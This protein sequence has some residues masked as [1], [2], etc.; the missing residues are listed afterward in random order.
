MSRTDEYF[1]DILRAFV[2]ETT[3]P[4]SEE[5]DWARIYWLAKIH[6]V[7]GII[8][9]MLK[10][11]PPEQQP[12]NEYVSKFF[13]I[14]NSTILCCAGRGIVMDRLLESYGD[15]GVPAVPMKGYIVRDFYPVKELRTFGD[16]DFLIREEDREKSHELMLAKGYIC[17]HP[18][19]TVF[20][21]GG[22]VWTYESA[23]KQ[24]MYEIHTSLLSANI[25]G[26]SEY[27]EYVRHAWEH[28][29]CVNHV[30][31]DG[32][33]NQYRFNETFHFIYVLLHLAKH[34]ASFGAGIRMFMDIA[35]I[36]K[37][38]P[39][40]DWDAVMREMRELELDDFFGMV[41]TLCNRWF[42]TVSPVE[43][44]TKVDTVL[45]DELSG[46]ILSGGVFG[47]EN[48]DESTLKMKKSRD[49]LGAV[50]GRKIKLHV[51]LKEL[52]A[53]FPFMSSRYPV[54]KKVPFLLPIFWVMR[55][56]DI[57]IHQ[58]KRGAQLVKGVFDDKDI[59][60]SY[61]MLSAMGLNTKR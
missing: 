60:K 3:I 47:F 8:G 50:S 13:Q 18:S 24:E 55:W 15:A 43:I 26:N 7:S 1:T 6:S 45:C 27:V 59:Q 48:E 52:F 33:T 44:G 51:I 20:Q 31:F 21:Q 19:L 54:L 25:N 30:N 61:R 29:N 9:Y 41:M 39:P 38:A 42:G 16:I 35:L 46:Y 56:I 12:V 23:N 37:A 28:V 11:L 53:E 2:N 40:I 4:I 5:V 17:T 10:Q 22:D 34:C 57:F 36:V 32:E 14:Y 49:S 58:R